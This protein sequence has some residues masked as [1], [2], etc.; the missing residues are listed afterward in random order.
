MLVLSGFLVCVCG[1]DSA[2]NQL[3]PEIPDVLGRLLH[4]WWEAHRDRS[5]DFGLHVFHNIYAI[6]MFLPAC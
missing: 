5:H 4:A 1:G 2:S 3:G 6:L